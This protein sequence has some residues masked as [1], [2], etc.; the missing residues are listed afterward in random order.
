MSP[1]GGVGINLAIQDAVAAANALAT[2]LRE[3]RLA[4]EH[5]RAVQ[6]RRELPTR[7][8]QR[9]QLVIQRRVIAR[10]LSR[11]RRRK[12]PLLLRLLARSPRLRRIPGRLIGVGVRPEHVATPVVEPR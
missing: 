6:H 5:L 2:P 11:R 7:V 8:I 3:R 10:V 9:L 1:I 4:T 12:P